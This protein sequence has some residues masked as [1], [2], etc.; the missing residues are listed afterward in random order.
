M[1]PYSALMHCEESYRCL[2]DCEVGSK[3]S[4]RL[5]DTNET[6]GCSGSHE[7]RGTTS[8]SKGIWTLLETE[9]QGVGSVSG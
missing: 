6:I 5:P 7:N 2:I 3:D 1:N 8:D 4:T 9:G